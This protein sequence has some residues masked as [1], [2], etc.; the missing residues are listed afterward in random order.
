MSTSVRRV[1]SAN[2]DE[3]EKVTHRS[4]PVAIIDLIQ[5]FYNNIILDR[6]AI[7][8]RCR[9]R[10][11]YHSSHTKH[12]PIRHCEHRKEL[13]GV[14]Q[15]RPFI[16]CIPKF[17]EPIEN[18]CCYHCTLSHQMYLMNYCLE[19]S[20]M[21]RVTELDIFWQKKDWKSWICCNGFFSNKKLD[22][23]D[24]RQKLYRL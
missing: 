1:Y 10:F 22:T 14:L 23:Y 17:Q 19:V 6:H 12:I 16:L 13:K 2:V 8:M 24:Y 3:F 21:R 9:E 15:H 4:F 18:V 5:E 7:C 11:R 20:N